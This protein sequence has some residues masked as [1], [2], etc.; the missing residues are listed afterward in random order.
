MNANTTAIT[1]YPNTEQ[2][3]G[4]ATPMML[5]L[6]GLSI[7]QNFLISQIK[8]MKTQ[9]KV[10]LEKLQD[11][12]QVRTQS[13]KDEH[14]AK[15]AAIRHQ[16]WLTVVDMQTAMQIVTKQ[17][18]NRY[19]SEQGEDTVSS[20]RAKVEEA[21][22]DLTSCRLDANHRIEALHSSLRLAQQKVQ[23]ISHDLEASS[24][25][26]Q[27]QD[28]LHVATLRSDQ[29]LHALDVRPLVPL[30]PTPGDFVFVRIS[31]TE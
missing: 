24:P 26:F 1:I 6:A 31:P 10:K 25:K 27:Q 28:L 29:C 9:H 30:R 2:T 15:T 12:H 7:D 4:S 3:A 11:E 17:F 8:A 21:K 20:L 16:H 13:L 19:L 18:C 23:K 22:K 14:Q 5:M